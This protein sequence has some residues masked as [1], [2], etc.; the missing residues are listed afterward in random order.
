MPAS[1]DRLTP[2]RPA[3]WLVTLAALVIVAPGLVPQDPSDSAAIQLADAFTAPSWFGA[4]PLGSDDQGRDIL[5]LLL[6]GLRLSLGIAALS[7]GLSLLIG[8]PLGLIAGWRKGALDSLIT[9]LADIQLTFP[10]ILLAMLIDGVLRILMP[11]SQSGPQA[12]VVIVIAIG[13]ANWVSFARVVRGSTRVEMAKTYVLAARSL[14]TGRVGILFRHILPNIAGPVIVLSSINLGTAIM[15]EATLSFLGIGL[16]PTLPSLGAL[17]ARG[18][19]FLFS[20]EWW[21]AV[22][23]GVTLALLIGLAN[24]AGDRLRRQ[25]SGGAGS[26][27]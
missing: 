24:L 22:L 16:P 4:F 5:A 19:N 26:G 14:G 13:F 7:V 2:W 10:A 27:V 20:G 15:T 18:Q 23:P 1:A 11:A 21:I 6:H 8:V 25:L 9:R 12:I 3:F 17:I